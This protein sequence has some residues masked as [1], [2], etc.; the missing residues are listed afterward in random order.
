MRGLVRYLRSSGQTDH[1]EDTGAQEIRAFLL[2]ETERTSA[3]SA[4]CHYRSL[5]VWFGWL[6]REGERAD[7][8][9][10]VVD[11]PKAA[12]KVKPF[13]AEADLAALLKSCS[14]TTFED[15]RDTAILRILTNTGVRVSGLAG[16]RYNPEDD[17]QTDVYLRERRLRITLKGGRQTYIPIGAKTA[18]ALDRYLRARAR[19]AHASSSWLWLG[20]RGTGVRCMT[21]SGV[22]QMLERRGKLAG[23]QGVHAHRFRHTFADSWLAAGGNVDDLMTIAGW[24]TYDMPLRYAGA[25]AW[26]EPVMRMHA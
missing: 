23:V 21:A 22:Q 25:G 1:I 16:L 11:K 17:S 18:A 4:Q 19:H 6:V 2:S 26:H 14:G 15:G 24:T 10:E 8:P 20:L 12:D 9:M 7:N 13:F 5:R 3:A